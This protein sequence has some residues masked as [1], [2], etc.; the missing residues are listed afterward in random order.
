MAHHR[1]IYDVCFP[2]TCNTFWRPALV[3][4]FQSGAHQRCGETV[5][6]GVHATLSQMKMVW[7]SE[8]SSRFVCPLVNQFNICWTL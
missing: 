2:D 4:I 8:K 1:N 7:Q 5:E 6:K 3:M